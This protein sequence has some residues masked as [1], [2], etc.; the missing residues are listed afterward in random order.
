MERNIKDNDEYYIDEKDNEDEK[1]I[2]L[3]N[4]NLFIEYTFEKD[5]HIDE[6]KQM[7]KNKDVKD[8]CESNNE[9]KNNN[10][11]IMNLIL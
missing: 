2:M 7:E 10:F 5:R 4:Q 1:E 6:L 8:E 9:D 11:K 3:M